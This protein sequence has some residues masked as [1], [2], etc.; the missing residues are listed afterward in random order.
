[1]NTIDIWRCST[2]GT[3]NQSQQSC[4]VCGT[5]CGGRRQTSLRE[6]TF[7]KGNNT[8]YIN[9][10]TQFNHEMASSGPML[11]IYTPPST[12]AV[13]SES[14]PLLRIMTVFMVILSFVLV[15]LVTIFLFSFYSYANHIKLERIMTEYFVINAI[16]DV[17]IVLYATKIK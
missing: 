15:A 5:E 4:G 10:P 3:G 2:C 14:N 9:A 13:A 6:E 7:H 1:M 8:F 16:I 12:R 17:C 11:P